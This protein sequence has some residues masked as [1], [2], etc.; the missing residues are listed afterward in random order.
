[1]QRAG[2]LCGNCC[3]CW[4]DLTDP[5]SLERG[6]GPECLGR[7]VEVIRWHHAHG[8]PV[9]I[10]AM[11]VGMPRAFVSEVIAEQRRLIA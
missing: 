1:M 6:I 2:R 7:I 10:I 11:I 9:E 5:I 8:R 4:R 3:I